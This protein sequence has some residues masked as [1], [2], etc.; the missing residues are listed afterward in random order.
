MT[1][2]VRGKL[3]SRV[4]T[5]WLKSR[6]AHTFVGEFSV[7]GLLILPA[8]FA[9]TDFHVFCSHWVLPSCGH[10][11]SFAIYSSARVQQILNGRW[12]S[13]AEE[14]RSSYSDT[15]LTKSFPRIKETL[16]V[17]SRRIRADSF[18]AQGS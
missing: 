11:L 1:T 9:L 16:S 13:S 5:F 18:E 8:R 7:G 4:T 6:P 17:A 2:T 10:I 15:N 14:P 12:W 3:K